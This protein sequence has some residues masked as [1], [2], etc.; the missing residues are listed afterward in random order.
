MHRGDGERMVR[1][2]CSRSRWRLAGDKR[3]ARAE[4]VARPLLAEGICIAHKKSLGA[5]IE[6][7]RT[8]NQHR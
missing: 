7:V 3:P 5:T 1:G 2:T 6:V 4:G 8:V